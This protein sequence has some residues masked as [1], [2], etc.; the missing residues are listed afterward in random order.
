M[1]T[2]SQA[3][4]IDLGSGLTINRIG[5]GTNRIENDDASRA[6]LEAAVERGINFIDTADIYTGGTSEEVIGATVASRDGVHVATKGGYH[7]AA[8]EVISAAIDNSLQALAL[9]SIEL[10]YLHRPDKKYAIEQSVEPILAA[11]R[12]GKV[13]H[14][15]LSSVSVEQI[16]KIQ[17]L[18]PV[19]AVQNVYNLDDTSNDDVIDYCSEHGIAFVPFFPLRGSK[20]A[21]PVAAKHG[22]TAQ[23]VILAAMLARSPIVVPIPGTRSVEHLESNLA[24][25]EL[26][27]SAEDLAELGIKSA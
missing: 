21:D 7:G 25:A 18:G 23:Q 9:D 16:E 1:P 20:K 8:P 10:Y 5:L 13:Q 27:L 15:G 6:I 3:G 19:S 26:E 12:D 17:K 14:L 24:A 11:Q 4:T 22:A 2:A